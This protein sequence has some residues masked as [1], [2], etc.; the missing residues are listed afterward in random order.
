M[1]VGQ[2]LKAIF[3]T[4]QTVD[5]DAKENRC[6]CCEIADEMDTIGPEAVLSRIDE[7]TDRVTASA[8]DLGWPNSK[9]TRRMIR[10]SIKAACRLASF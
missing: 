5:C 2:T 10:I 7:F 8:E 9:W 1:K 3:S 6:Q 4:I